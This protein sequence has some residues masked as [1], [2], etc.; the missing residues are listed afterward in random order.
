MLF[1]EALH[2]AALFAEGKTPEVVEHT[3]DCQT[4]LEE[5]IAYHR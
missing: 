2:G 4:I 1:S 3:T 5:A